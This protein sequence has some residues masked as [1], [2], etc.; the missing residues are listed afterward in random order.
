[1]LMYYPSLP[2]TLLNELEILVC[3]IW[4]WHVINI[5]EVLTE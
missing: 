2:Q 1:M 5:Q 3:L 4:A